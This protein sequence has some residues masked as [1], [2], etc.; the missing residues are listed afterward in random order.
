MCYGGPY[1]RNDELDPQD[2][3][4]YHGKRAKR[5][6]QDHPE[7]IEVNSV[8]YQIQRPQTHSHNYPLILNCSL[9]TQLGR[10]KKYII[11]LPKVNF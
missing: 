3:A 8:A 2:R 6:R 5:M 11:T 10:H 4:K 1:C 9:S 7:G